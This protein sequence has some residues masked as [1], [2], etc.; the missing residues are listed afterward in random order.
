[1]LD[2]LAAAYAEAGDFDSAVKWETKAI[3]LESDAHEK[4]EYA[5]RLKLYRDK[6]PYRDPM[7]RP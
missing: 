5:E 6:K 1:M 3:E 7:P 4:A 2:T